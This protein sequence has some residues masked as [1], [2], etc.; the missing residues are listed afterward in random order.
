MPYGKQISMA[1]TIA[2]NLVSAAIPA[3]AGDEDTDK[4]KDTDGEKKK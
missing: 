3:A 2:M 1:I 4:D